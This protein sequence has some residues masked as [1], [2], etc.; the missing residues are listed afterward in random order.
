MP[1]S[2]QEKLFQEILSNVNQQ[3]DRV[4]QIL[5]K[6]L[7]IDIKADLE[8]MCMGGN[9][10]CFFLEDEDLLLDDDLGP[11][12]SRRSKL[13]LTPVQPKYLQHLTG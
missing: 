11:N 3:E 9:R 6:T 12:A 10:K 4:G 7:K 13:Q 8:L 2:E 5:K 1:L